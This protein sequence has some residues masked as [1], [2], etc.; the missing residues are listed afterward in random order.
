MQIPEVKTPKFGVITDYPITAVDRGSYQFIKYTGEDPVNEYIGVELEMRFSPHM[1]HLRN[2]V[3]YFQKEY[4]NLNISSIGDVRTAIASRI[5]SK[6][7]L[8]KGIPH[9]DGG[10]L[11]SVLQP[12]TFAAHQ[13]LKEEYKKLLNTYYA[14]GF[15]PQQ[16]GDGIHHYVDYG[17]LG[18]REG[19][20]D[21]I[22]L[23]HWFLFENRDFLSLAS[24]RPYNY[25]SV[26]DIHALL[27]DQL[28]LWSEER[29]KEAFIQ[30][31]EDV[32]EYIRGDGDSWVRAF[33]ISWGRDG[34][35]AYEFR[36]FGSTWDIDEFMAMIELSH[37][38]ATFVASHRSIDQMKLDIFCN[39]VRD[40]MQQYPHLIEELYNNQISAPLMQSTIGP[41][42]VTMEAV[43]TPRKVA[44]W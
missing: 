25:S 44:M 31:K 9:Y 1:V 38:M 26:A 41:E 32:L 11:E 8:V 24:K 29:L 23:L 19:L 22:I 37:A 30:H 33:N 27:G 20:E 16:G 28:G 10:G 6:S 36:W 15:N 5:L 2:I 40:N 12:S 42:V 3:K 14:F 18:P 35:P 39:Y 17:L 13:V 21:S 34:R 4:K 7:F 43:V